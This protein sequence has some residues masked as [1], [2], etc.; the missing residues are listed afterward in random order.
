[1][2]YKE[3]YLEMVRA[4]ER[5]LRQMQQAQEELIRAQRRCEE[6]YL[7]QEEQTP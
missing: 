4:S 3:M 6:L 7:A 2:D 1:M 5:A